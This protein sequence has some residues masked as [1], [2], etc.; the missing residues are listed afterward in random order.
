[1]EKIIEK[2][3]IQSVSLKTCINAIIRTKG[4]QLQY[5]QQLNDSYPQYFTK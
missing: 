5:R 3:K 1:M 4:K 2:K